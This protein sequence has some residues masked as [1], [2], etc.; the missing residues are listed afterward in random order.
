MIVKLCENI[1]VDPFQVQSID[2]HTYYN[3]FGNPEGMKVIV[4]F[5]NGKDINRIG[6]TSDEAH[7]AVKKWSGIIN[8]HTGST[9]TLG[10]RL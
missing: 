2:C 9:E 10:Q 1:F 5:K 3:K 8:K 4:T 7:E 6:F